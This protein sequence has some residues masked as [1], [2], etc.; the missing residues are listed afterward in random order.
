MLFRSVKRVYDDLIDHD[1]NPFE[2]YDTFCKGKTISDG[3]E[4]KLLAHL[5]SLAKQYIPKENFNKF[6]NYLPKAHKTQS[7]KPKN[8]EL[9]HLKKIAFEKAHYSFLVDSYVM[10]NVLPN[11][12]VKIRMK[13][14]ELFQCID[15]MSDL[16]EDISIDKPT[17]INQLNNPEKKLFE[18][19]NKIK[20]YLEK[21]GDKPILYLYLMR[22]FIDTSIN[23]SSKGAK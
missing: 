23:H 1:N 9:E 13:S 7:A 3:L 16:K 12:F 20:K 6:Y 10:I 11:M 2:V 8:K 4:Y 19:F 17:Y 14:A 18:K 5:G 21:D 15:D 22:F